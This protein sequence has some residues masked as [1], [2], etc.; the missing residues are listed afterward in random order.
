[1]MTMTRHR[2]LF[3]P[4]APLPFL[5]QVLT[6]V[7]W[8]TRYA[9]PSEDAANSYVARLR[10]GNGQPMVLREFTAPLGMVNVSTKE[11]GDV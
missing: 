3:D 2:V 6:M 1:M 4:S 8:V 5:V 11:Y 7:G 10:D 9:A